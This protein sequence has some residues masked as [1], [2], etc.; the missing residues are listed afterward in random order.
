MDRPG[1]F[2]FFQAS[3][4]LFPLI[5]CLFLFTPDIGQT[6]EL[7]GFFGEGIDFK[8]GMLDWDVDEAGHRVAILRNYA[9]VILP[10]L[11]VSARNMILNIE[12]QEIYAEGDVLFDEPNGNAFYCDQLTFN[13][14]EWQGL[15]KNVRVKMDRAGVNIPVRDFLDQTPSVNLAGGTL[16]DTA[17]GTTGA[18]KRMY[19]QAREL[20]AHDSN[21]LELIDAKITPDGFARPHWYFRSPAAIFR[22][23][24]KIESYHNTVNIGRLPVFY[25]PY[26]IRD[27]QYDWPWMRITGGYSGDYGAFV[28]TQWGWRLAER[29]GKTLKIDRFIFDLDWFSARGAGAGFET[30]Y[31]LGDLESVGKLKIYGVYEYGITQADDEKRA[32]DYNAS[33]TR[34]YY[35]DKLR[36]AVDW[37]HFQQLN[38]FWDIRAEAHLY[39]DRDY[40]REYDTSRY[41]NAKTPENSIDLRR[42]DNNWELE[43][44]ASSRLSNRWQTNAEYFPEARLTIP[45]LRLGDLPLF[46]KDDL[47]VGVINRRFDEDLFSLSKRNSGLGSL[48]MRD[49]GTGFSTSRLVDDA[50]FGTMFRAFNELRLEAPLKVGGIFTFKPWLGLR[51]AYYSETMG[52]VDW[53][54]PNV[55]AGNSPFSASDLLRAKGGGGGY[56]AVPFGADL[57]TRLY[58]IFGS[59]DQWRLISEPVLSYL[60]NSRPKLDSREDLY[61]VDDFDEYFRQRRVGFELHEK[62]QRREY[63]NAPGE[64]IPQRDILDFN[65]ALYHYPHRKDRAEISRGYY[66]LHTPISPT[67]DK[68]SQSEKTNSLF[69]YSELSLDLIF[70]PTGRLSLSASGDYD[71]HDR[72]FNRAI[73]SADWRLGSMFRAYISHYYY[74]GRYWRYATAEPSSQTHFAVR[75]KLW[76]DSS[77]YSIEGA[78]AYEWRNSS[79]QDAA[80][81]VRHGFNK[82]RLTVYR[83]IDTFELAFSYVRDRNGDDHGVFFSL[84]P[85]SF[86]GYD[87]PSPS[88][89]AEVAP[90]ASGRYPEASRYL[91]SGY[92]IDAPVA[93]ADLK[94]VQF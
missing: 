84:S 5:L 47:R 75:T 21:T 12:L 24:E 50:D 39:H 32:N 58:T 83:D 77:H 87:R 44:V 56:Y 59:H 55:Q 79:N 73:V 62:L 3:G 8:G 71:L 38:D 40:L 29:E 68:Y 22:K 46:L 41:W 43:F 27:L 18:L 37:E 33:G 31:R 13:Y 6:G 81:G 20:R 63:E 35:R 11:T 17:A 42:L 65:L 14:Q 86:M 78:V 64:R 89:T 80:D 2:K 57:S 94:D 72:T 1:G 9:V 82:Y 67:Y 28:R 34:H 85:K 23:K 7:G 54:N 26:L 90:L 69:R 60:E 30:S 61:P 74:R 53:D 49:P 52:T 4:L 88:Y 76:N 51:T 16:N 19:A 93:D 70:R 48:F 10:Q 25:F 45:G 15:A 91:E 36:W 66:S 92:R